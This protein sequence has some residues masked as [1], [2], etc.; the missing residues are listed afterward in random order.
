MALKEKAA[1]LKGLADGLDFD[2]TT[3]EGKL[4]AAILELLGEM[5]ADIEEIEE[6]IDYLGDYVEEVDKDLGELEEFCYEDDCDCCDCDDDDCDCDCDCDDDFV[7][8]ECPACGDTICIDEDTDF[9]HVECPACGA[10]FS[11]VCDCCDE[12]DDDCDCCHHD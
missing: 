1:Y 4:L 2:K 11:C 10:E 6:S 12:D 8:V 5:T 3:A 7:E 9:N